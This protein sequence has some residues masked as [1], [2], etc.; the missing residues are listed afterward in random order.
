MWG[1]RESVLNAR[2]RGLCEFDVGGKRR[3]VRKK[4]RS[5]EKETEG[6]GDSSP[7]Q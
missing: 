1:K 6:D 4:K 2:S 7:V 5:E 3:E